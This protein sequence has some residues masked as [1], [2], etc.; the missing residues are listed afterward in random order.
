V[1]DEVDELIRML[2]DKALS[3]GVRLGILIA[4][5]YIDGYVTFADL[6]RDLDIPKSSLHQHL[7]MLQENGLVEFKRGITPLGVRTVVKITNKGKG[8]V[9]RYL[10]LV[11]ALR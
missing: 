6:Q 8:I 4:L 3:S 1:V 9:S 2:K 11:R 10:E 5:Y 7:S